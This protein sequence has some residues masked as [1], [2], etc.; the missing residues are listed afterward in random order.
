MYVGNRYSNGTDL[1]PSSERV[2]FQT[3]THFK[4]QQRFGSSYKH[5]KQ[6]KYKFSNL[7]RFESPLGMSLCSLKEPLNVKQDQS[8]VLPVKK[9]EG[10][11]PERIPFLVNKVQI[12]LQAI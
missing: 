5:A 7:P 11:P 10:S 9:I 3:M 12:Y 2:L 8:S 4:L 1:T 6:Q